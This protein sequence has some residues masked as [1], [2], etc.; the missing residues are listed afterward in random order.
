MGRLLRISK[1]VR[2]LRQHFGDYADGSRM[3]RILGQITLACHWIGCAWYFLGDAMKPQGTRCVLFP[4]STMRIAIN[5][6]STEHM[7]QFCSWLAVHGLDLPG[8][9]VRTKYLK[10][11]YY[12]VTLLTSVGYGDMIPVTT[13]E[14]IFTAL[15]TVVG[16]GI[17]ASVFSNFVSYV[18]R[19]DLME[20]KY[21]DKKTLIETQMSYLQ[22]PEM[23]KEKIL[24]Y[25]EYLSLRHRHLLDRGSQFYDELP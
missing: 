17:Y 10:S 21:Q 4:T 12:S 6:G 11:I 5:T 2:I 23:L 15:I 19:N 3:V 14:C 13:P 22:F 9:S 1:I 7:S 20:I 16:A 25:Y 8:A 18:S 24:D